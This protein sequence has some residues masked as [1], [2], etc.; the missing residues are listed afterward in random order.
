MSS[1][2]ELRHVP[3]RFLA[4]ALGAAV[5]LLGAHAFPAPHIARVELDLGLR[6]IGEGVEPPIMAARKV[7]RVARQIEG[8]SDVFVVVDR[9]SATSSGRIQLEVHA[10]SATVAG[11][12]AA[13]ASRW[14]VEEHHQLR[15]AERSVGRSYADLMRSIVGSGSSTKAAAQTASRDLLSVERALETVAERDT[16]ASQVAL[17]HF[18]RG[19]ALALIGALVGLGIGLV[20]IVAASLSL[21]LAPILVATVVAASVGAA[22]GA[23]KKPAEGRVVVQVGIVDSEESPY[24][25]T[26]YARWI[27]FDDERYSTLRPKALTDSEGKPT[28]FL[29]ISTSG[30]DPK[31]VERELLEAATASIRVAERSYD[32]IQSMMAMVRQDLGS[33]AD[34]LSPSRDG[35]AKELIRLGR[36]QA[37]A[38][39]RLSPARTRP[40]SIAVG[41]IVRIKPRLVSASEL[42][43]AF[44]ASGAVIAF[45]V[46]WM[47]R[48]A[49]VGGGE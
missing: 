38:K 48:F 5:G 34:S 36:I 23:L 10:R 47:R 37:R 13:E 32:R 2:P 15:Q 42:A 22:L 20:P 6:A 49:R 14:L 35:D 28:G 11:R 43:A 1:R 29:E 45:S 41:P 7:E 44:G 30:D 17:S 3:S 18:N 8:V 31:K 26:F 46:L 21:P 33:A 9:S 27:S 39:R 40:P 24:P 4:A 19:P 25:A 16:T 12:A